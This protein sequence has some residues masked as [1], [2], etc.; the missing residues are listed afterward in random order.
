[1]RVDQPIPYPG[2]LSL[3]HIPDF[4]ELRVSSRTGDHFVQ[5]HNAEAVGYVCS[6]IT[7]FDVWTSKSLKWLDEWVIG[8]RVWLLAGEGEPTALL[9]MSHVHCR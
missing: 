5:Y 1:M 4:H 8:N 9:R 7:E 3:F 2:R 6:Q